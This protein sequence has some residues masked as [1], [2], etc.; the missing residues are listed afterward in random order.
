MKKLP[1]AGEIK[2]TCAP[3]LRRSGVRKS[4]LFGSFAG[5]DAT[6]ASDGDLLVDFAPRTSLLDVVRLRDDLRDA[7]GRKVDLVSYRAVSPRLKPY[8]MKDL[9]RIV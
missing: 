1:T 6:R 5:G 7:L 4:E 3:I 2:R 8:I 9:F